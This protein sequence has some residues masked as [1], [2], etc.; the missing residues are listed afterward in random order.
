MLQLKENLYYVGVQDADLRVFDIIM[1]TPCGTSYNA[2]VLKGS[3]KTA[4]IDASKDGFQEEFLRRVLEVTPL[5]KIDYLII[6]H[7]EPD[8]AGI[9]PL[10]VAKNPD[11]ELIG[12]NSAIT[13]ITNIIKQPFKSRI[14]KKGDTLD[15]GDRQL[16]F[17]PMPNLHWPDTMFV[18][19]PV[20]EA[21]FTCDF[22]GAH[23][24]WDQVLL[25]KM[26]DKTAYRT[27]QHQYFMDIMAPF[28]K[29]FAANG[30]KCAKELQP[31]IICTGH[32]PVLDVDIDYTLENYEKWCEVPARE[33][34]SVAIVYVSAYKYTKTLADVI[35]ETLKKEGVAVKMMEAT[36]TS[37][38]DMLGEISQSTGVLFGSPTFLGD[39]LKPIGEVLTA[40]YPFM[41][42]GKKAS[43]FGSYGWSG[44]AVDNILERAKQLKMKTM[45]GI[46]VR[47]RPS[48]EE[49]QT[50]RDF[51]RQFAQQL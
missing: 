33:G 40:L 5:E 47:L 29:P 42:S 25:S 50:A 4:L 39:V 35:A 41:V 3:Q 6:N 13:F 30:V 38:D 12:T 21:L 7:T 49:L 15:L 16:Q 44:E 1:N 32:G 26:L 28:R 22:F 48:E 37:M 36:S 10:L 18:Y 9:I 27:A 46:K 14:V 8:H 11:L 45:D 34:K 43:A 24:S 19:D 20:T 17:Y 51:A 31:K 23:F 2:Y